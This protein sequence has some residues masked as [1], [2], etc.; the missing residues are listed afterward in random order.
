M[1]IGELQKN[2]AA[3][4]GSL[5]IASLIAVTACYPLL[6][7]PWYLVLPLSIYGGIVVIIGPFRRTFPKIAIGHFDGRALLSA[8]VLAVTTTVVLVCF[9]AI[10]HPDL[11]DLAARIPVHWF[12]NLLIAGV[13]FSV[14]NAAVE[15]LIFRGIFWDLVSDEWNSGVAL[16]VTALLFG[17]GH[18]DGYPPGP[19]GAILAGVYGLL[20]GLLRWWTGGLGL[21]TACH[22]GAD[23]T[24]FCILAGN[25]LFDAT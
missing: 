19:I 25:G 4:H 16:C 15:E 22:I 3:M 10:F 13:C 20:L 24:I 11:S 6:L 12:G 14:L 17:V 18:L 1:S 2:K 21:A 23:A 8:I 5:F 7:W 9:Q